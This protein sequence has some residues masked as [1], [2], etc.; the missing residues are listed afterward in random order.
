MVQIRYMTSSCRVNWKIKKLSY[1]NSNWIFKRIP[2]KSK[3]SL[4]TFDLLWWDDFRNCCIHDWKV[5]KPRTE[6]QWTHSWRDQWKT[7]SKN[8]IFGDK[9]LLT[10]GPQ[11]W[12]LLQ[13]CCKCLTN[14]HHITK[15]FNFTNILHSCPHQWNFCIVWYWGRQNFWSL[16]LVN[17]LSTFLEFVTWEF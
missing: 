9:M 10:T 5:L 8:D 4:L 14:E 3:S 15:T 16:F 17:S 12:T 13:L 11:E 2:K 1:R 7:E 6:N